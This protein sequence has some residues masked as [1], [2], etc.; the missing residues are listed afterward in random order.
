MPSLFVSASVTLADRASLS[1]P[2]PVAPLDVSVACAILTRGSV[3]SP[4]AKATGALSTSELTPPAGIVAPLV[5]NAVPPA[6]P[7]TVP[8]VAMPVG[9]HA[10]VPVSVTPAGSA[11]LT[12]TA[13]ASLMPP[14]VTV[15]WYVAVP[16]GVYDA[17]PSVFTTA[18]VTLGDRASLS[19]ALAV[20]PDATSV[21]LTVLTS[22]SVVIAAANAT[23]TV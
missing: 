10:T 17:E 4:A 18:I 8:Q 22:G 11:S 13:S 5:P 15:T 2:L 12:F 19:E 14:L 9:V 1:L 16:P 20:A 3:V 6:I 7:D 21:T 23:G